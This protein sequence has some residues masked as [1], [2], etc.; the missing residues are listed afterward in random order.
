MTTPPSRLARS[1]RKSPTLALNETAA[2]LRAAGE[3]VIHLGG[4]EPRSPAPLEAIEACT[5]RLASREVRYAPAD[6]LPEMKDA[7]VRW[8]EAHYGRAVRRDNVVVSSGAKQALMV[9]LQS[10]LDPGEEVVFP[11]PYWVSYPEMVRLAG[12]VGVP[13]RAA[14]GSFQPKLSEVAAA[15]TE[16]TRAVILNSPNNP[17]GAVYPRGF[18][19]EVAELCAAR[20]VWL[21]MDDIYDRLVFDDAS[22]TS[23]Y[24]LVAE[25][26]DVARVAV[27]QGVSKAFAMTGFRIGWAVAPAEVAEAM[28]NIQS[29]Q[30]SGPATPSQWAAVAALEAK[31]PGTD[32]LRRTLQRQRDVLLE[33]L[34]R[35]PDVAVTIPSGTFYCF[36][37]F[38]RHDPDA[39]RLAARLLEEARVVTVPGAE[40][41][42]EG[43]LRLS[44]CGALP[45]IE[46]GLDRIR[47]VLAR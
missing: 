31:E 33:R 42:M 14:D 21:V 10:I 28:A 43:H 5:R 32:E 6:G 2:R 8:T 30:T 13:V 3:P 45:E 29:H 34:R 18:V 27:I 38:S 26:V 39:Q 15:F 9:L 25:E 16:A 40:F 7:V 17:S 36:P 4:G 11:A 37:D 12:G 22:A 24:G 35:I 44:Y 23:I 20:G 1:I 19:A 41:G 46:E 47:R